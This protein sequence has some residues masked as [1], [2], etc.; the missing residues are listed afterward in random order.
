MTTHPIAIIAI[1]AG[2]GAGCVPGFVWIM[3]GVVTMMSGTVRDGSVP[4]SPL[5][6]AVSFRYNRQVRYVHEDW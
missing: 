2:S 1:S 3:R 5:P 6:L 4:V